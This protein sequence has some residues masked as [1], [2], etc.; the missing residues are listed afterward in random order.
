MKIFIICALL[1]F[2]CSGFSQEPADAV[3]FAQSITTANLRRQLNIIAG[4]DMEGRET[5]TEGQR[6]AAAYIESQFRSLGLLPAWNGNFQQTY[7]V[8]QDSLVRSSIS[9]N[10]IAFEPDSDFV[11]T[12]N[13]SHNISFN[14][15]EVLFAGYGRSDSLWDDYKNINARGKIVLVL[16][17]TPALLIKGKKVK[18]RAVDLYTLQEASL[19]NGAIGLLIMDKNFPMNPSPAKGYAYVNDYRK[20]NYPNTFFIS[21][22]I[23]AAIMGADFALAKKAIKTASP[24]LKS[25]LISVLLELDKTLITMESSNV[26]SYIEGTDKKE[27]ALIITAHYDHLGKKGDSAIYQGADDD[28]SGTVSVLE[29]F[30]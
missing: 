27:E 17:G 23:A 30:A 28:G 15:S 13:S 2:C 29:I 22:K 14:A 8:F 10:G 12:S 19:K 26:L 9:I 1:A 5:A 18:L 4:K 24:V 7:P 11:V 16:P 20:L 25:Y 3:P 21:E 6:K